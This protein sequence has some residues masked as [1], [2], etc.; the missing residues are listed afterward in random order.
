[1]PAN[2][3]AVLRAASPHKMHHQPFEACASNAYTA[4][5]VMVSGVNRYGPVCV[6]EGAFTYNGV[7]TY[8]DNDSLPPTLTF[9]VLWLNTHMLQSSVINLVH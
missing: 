3:C 9:F 5:G 1:M 6:S 2:R 7:H 8:P 4:L